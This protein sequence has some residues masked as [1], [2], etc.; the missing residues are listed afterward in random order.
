MQWLVKKLL[1]IRDERNANNRKNA[2]NYFSTKFQNIKPE[3]SKNYKKDPNKFENLTH[4]K[5]NYISTGRLFRP[6][7]KNN[8]D[9]ND[10][11]FILL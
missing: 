9:Y 7:N 6:T 10:P 4:S 8:F 11:L 2:S 3:N 1:E 5:Y